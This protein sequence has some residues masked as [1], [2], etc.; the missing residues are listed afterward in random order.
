[1]IVKVVVPEYPED[2]W[3]EGIVNAITHRDYS[4]TGESILVSIFDDRMEI[5]SPGKLPGLVTIDNIKHERCSRNPRIARFLF[6]FGMVK[7]LN[8]GVPR[9]F[10]EMNKYFLEEPLY[11]EPNN[12]SVK[13]TLKNNILSR[14]K[15]NMD[16]IT[17]E[18]IVKDNW[19]N[20]T[21]EE[22]IAL[23]FIYNSGETTAK[24]L[25]VHLNVGE[26][27][28]RKIL[29]NLKNKNIIMWTGNGANDKTGKYKTTF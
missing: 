10:S 29:N 15:R 26:T 17:T 1:M 3:K 28:V 8:E 21:S 2:A 14:A 9:I 13:L 23:T 18:K 11:E 12:N 20:L 16:R 5:K 19:I 22:K 6:E 4:N 25:V 24:E 27:K 7:E